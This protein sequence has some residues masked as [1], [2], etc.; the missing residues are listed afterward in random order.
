MKKAFTVLE[1]IFVI[2]ILGI[3]AAIALP[4]LGTSKDEAMISKTLSNLKTTINDFT[5][6]ALKN[7]TL[8]NTS[9]M[10]NVDDLENVD[11]STINGTAN[12]NF[13]VGSDE[14]CLSLVFANENNILL[15]GIASN[16]TV[17]NL[18]I[19]LARAK[20]KTLVNPNDNS[21]KNEL[22]NA[23]KALA[24]ADFTSSSNNKTCKAL[25]NNAQFK[26]MASRVYALIG[27]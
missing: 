20:N 18:I 6:Y 24:N 21:A 11:L 17:K 12:V 8:A 22:D 14:N 5:Q 10:S 16:D 9:N 26:S 27:G 4:K 19:E 2:I 23:S 13:R 1:L 3:L 25:S 15:F 7:D